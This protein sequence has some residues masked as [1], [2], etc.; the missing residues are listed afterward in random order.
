MEGSDK[1]DELSE[2][3]HLAIKNS[4]RKCDSFTKYNK[5]QFLVMLV[6]TNEENCQIAINRIINCF[7]KDHKTWGKYLECSVSS[8]LDMEY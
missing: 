8:L 6:G 5:S 7:V 1:L 2:G 3:L 4:L